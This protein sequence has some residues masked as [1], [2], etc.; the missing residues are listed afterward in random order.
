MNW[1][2]LLITILAIVIP[3]LV[4]L[5]L[6]E[7]YAR[8]DMTESDIRQIY[9]EGLRIRDGDNPYKRIIDNPG[10]DND[11]PTYLPGFYLLAAATRDIAGKP[12]QDWLTFWRAIFF[13]CH[14]GIGYIIFFRLWRRN[15]LLF[16]VVGSSLWFFGRWSLM[17]LRIA[18]QEPLAILLL[19]LSLVLMR[20]HF[21]IACVLFGMSLAVK[22][23]A[24][25]MFPVYLMWAWRLDDDPRTRIRNTILA[26]VC[27]MAVPLA[28]SLSFIQ[29]EP[30]GFIKSLLF[31]VNRKGEAN[32]GSSGDFEIPSIDMLLRFDDNLENTVFAPVRRVIGKVFLFGLMLL[33]YRLAYR[34][35]IRPFALSLLILLIFSD[36]HSVFFPQYVV[37]PIAML[38][39]ALG[40]AGTT[41]RREW[42]RRRRRKNRPREGTNEHQ[43]LPA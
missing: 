25:F 27:C 14:L 37:W 21:M 15:S 4:L 39:L 19:M 23:I 42:R 26:A 1:K 16:A 10:S 35:Q 8:H 41:A 30:M 33:S 34:R 32:V 38:P 28:V 29:R 31:S 24:V 9:K 17:V 6:L 22:Q 43:A 12:F 40:E 20:R 13:A 36:F 11:Y 7:D 18:H 2:K 5:P 3:F